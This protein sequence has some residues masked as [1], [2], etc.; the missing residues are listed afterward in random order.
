MEVTSELKLTNLTNLDIGSFQC[1]VNNMYGATYSP[2]ADITVYVFPQFVLTPEDK[3]VTGGTSVTLKCSATGF[4]M[5]DISWQKDSGSDF[6]AARERRMHV[7][8]DT[9]TYVIKNVKAD[10]MGVYTC[11]ATNLAGSVTTNTSITVLEV[12]RFVKPMENKTVIS[13]ENAVLECQASGAPRPN[14]V[15]SKNGGQLVAT[16]RHFF[17]ADNQLLIIVKVEPEDVGQYQCS[18]HNSLGTVSGSSFLTIDGAGGETS[19]AGGQGTATSVIVI[20]VV[21]CVL[22]TSA[23]WMVIICWTRTRSRSRRKDW[24]TEEMTSKDVETPTTGMPLLG[25]A[26]KE[27]DSGSERDSGTGDSKKSGEAEAGGDSIVDTVIHNFLA[28]RG[29]HGG[30][31]VWANT[32]SLSDFDTGISSLGDST[33]IHNG[34]HSLHSLHRRG[35]PRVKSLNQK[36]Q[37]QTAKSVTS[38]PV[39]V[40]SVISYAVDNPLYDSLPLTVR[41]QEAVAETSSDLTSASASVISDSVAYCGRFPAKSRGQCDA[42]SS[43]ASVSSVPQSV[44]SDQPITFN[45]FHPLTSSQPSSLRS[46]HTKQRKRLSAIELPTGETLLPISDL[47]VTATPANLE[48]DIQ[49]A[50]EYRGG[51][52]LP[53]KGGIQQEWLEASLKY[54]ALEAVARSESERGS[55]RSKERGSRRSIFRHSTRRGQAGDENRRKSSGNRRSRRRSSEAGSVCQSN[56]EHSTVG[57]KNRDMF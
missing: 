46:G 45:T 35:C 40:V 56:D 41:P 28:A 38:A 50:K 42:A 52:T 7:D 27:D 57:S 33:V 25:E 26:A 15:W 24:E 51:G 21:S 36:P 43:V 11:S 5:P 39:P 3:T 47:E 1:I 14:L 9:N 16:E 20:A 12:P 37:P 29:E 4:P 49:A 19:E 34:G 53:R 44:V 13:G 31:G 32:T 17:T 23:V 55:V 18:M 48:S 54:T 2:K 10:D 22:G 6:P 30:P 8:P